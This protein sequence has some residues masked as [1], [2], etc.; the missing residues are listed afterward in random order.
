MNCPNRHNVS[1]TTIRCD[2]LPIVIEMV[3]Q[4]SVNCPCHQ[5]EAE[6]VN[7]EAPTANSRPECLDDFEAVITGKYKTPTERQ[8]DE[9]YPTLP[10]MVGNFASAMGRLIKAKWHGQKTLVSEER[11]L[12]V[13][14]CCESCSYWDDDARRG[15]GKC[16]APGCG[17]TRM[18]LH[19]AT[20]ACTKG[21]WDN[22][23]ET[24]PVKCPSL[25]KV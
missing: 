24:I 19:I 8:H 2:L 18:K 10:E 3:D 6:W 23:D 21:G 20:E 15:Y 7:G 9:P 13:L 25:R 5:C 17:C 22:R 12:Q 16:N 1:P 4:S 14:Q 11:F